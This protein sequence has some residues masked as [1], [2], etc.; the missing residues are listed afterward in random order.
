MQYDG[1]DEAIPTTAAIS[2]DPKLEIP[3]NANNIQKYTFGLKGMIEMMIAMIKT[4]IN[5]LIPSLARF[6]GSIKFG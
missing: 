3:I 1:Y 2:D 5:N 4:L 6:I